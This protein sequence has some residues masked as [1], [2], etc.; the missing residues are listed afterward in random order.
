MLVVVSVKLSAPEMASIM[1]KHVNMQPENWCQQDRIDSRCQF[2][3]H[4]VDFS[5][6]NLWATHSVTTDPSSPPIMPF[7]NK[8]NLPLNP[9]REKTFHQAKAS[10]TRFCIYIHNEII[11]KS[12]FTILPNSYRI[13]FFSRWLAG[14]A[15]SCELF[16]L[17]LSLAIKMSFL[18]VRKNAFCGSKR[19]RDYL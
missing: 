5:S 12:S 17:L 19:V 6:S 14:L 15:G 4:K 2:H 18:D 7:K 10:I 1:R 8:L 3:L 13:K 11:R 9:S 16:F